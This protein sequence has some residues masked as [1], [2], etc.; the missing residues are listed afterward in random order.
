MS[1]NLYKIADY[2]EFKLHRYATSISGPKRIEID[3]EIV[4]GIVLPIF[5]QQI[6]EQKRSLIPLAKSMLHYFNK[7]EAS[8]NKTN[9]PSKDLDL[10]NMLEGTDEV[11]KNFYSTIF[12]IGEGELRLSANK[13]K[14]SW[15]ISELYIP[16]RFNPVFLGP[17][18]DKI[19]QEIK[20]MKSDLS[21]KITLEL[22]KNHKNSGDIINNCKIIVPKH[23]ITLLF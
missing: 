1:N 17:F 6:Q 3:S 19:T 11:K 8:E 12:V 22:N 20:K 10:K 2:F 9:V 5:E 13:I 18:Q 7:L 23:D 4:K 21:K 15:T 14:N 16:Y